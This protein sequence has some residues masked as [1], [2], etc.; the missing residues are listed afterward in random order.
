M[1]HLHTGEGEYDFTVSGYLVHDNKTLLIKHKYLP[2]WTPPSGHVEHNQTPLEAL[3]TEIKEEAGITKDHVT[4]LETSPYKCNTIRSADSTGIPVPFDI[5]YHAINDEHS[6][7]NLSYIV[8][9]DTDN[10]EPEA[11]ESHTF[12]WFTIDELRQFTDTSSTITNAAIFAIETVQGS[13]K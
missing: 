7:I 10:V 3:Y 5:D 12:A 4:I 8:T 9:S 1:P 11:G 6:H 13:V 2:L